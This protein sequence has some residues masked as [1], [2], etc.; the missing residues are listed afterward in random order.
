MY[1]LGKKPARID[2]RNLRFRALLPKKL[3]EPPPEYD[4][5]FDN[6]DIWPLPLPMFGNDKYGCCVIAGRANQ[7]LRF[8]RIEQSS[9]IP[10][11]DDDVLREYWLEGDPTGKTKPDEGLYILDSL[12]CWRNGW[13]AAGRSYNIYAFAQINKAKQREIQL[14]I[15]LLSGLQSG[16]LLRQSDMDQLDRKE[17]WSLTKAPGGVVGGHCMFV[18]GY[19]RTGPVFLTWGQRM[20][21]TWDWFL[22]RCDE[23][24]GVV[25]DR[26]KFGDSTLDVEK[27]DEFLRAVTA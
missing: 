24:Y 8:E 17:I 6:E 26:N 13:Q 15:W 22:S 9:A 18:I 7:T 21:A 11:T 23:I 20:A 25:D 1:R 27:L 14:A 19:T 3:P 16:V 10:I 2:P 4:V 12:K 5:D